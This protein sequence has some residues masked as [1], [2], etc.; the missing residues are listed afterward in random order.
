MLLCMYMYQCW[1]LVDTWEDLIISN[2]PCKGYNNSQKLSHVSRGMKCIE[3]VSYAQ[4]D[5]Q[6]MNRH[7]SALHRTF[8]IFCAKLLTNIFYTNSD[9]YAHVCKPVRT[10]NIRL[11]SQSQ[12]AVTLPATQRLEGRLTRRLGSRGG[13]VCVWRCRVW[14][15]HLT[16]VIFICVRA[17]IRR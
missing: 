8:S 15:L 6:N 4:K 7:D 1:D 3:H 11:H 14:C 10:H 13:G 5:A 12:G 2:L 9:V 17:S 16:V